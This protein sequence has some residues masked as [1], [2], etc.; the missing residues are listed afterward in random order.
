MNELDRVRSILTVGAVLD[1]KARK[2]TVDLPANRRWNG[3][4]P[5]SCDFCCDDL[6]ATEL[7]VDG[8]TRMG[9]WALMCPECHDLHGVGVGTG[10]GQ[11]YESDTLEKFVG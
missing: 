6:Q 11:A 7:F 8:R 9:P 4:W 1:H 3:N 2:T 5:A 10:K